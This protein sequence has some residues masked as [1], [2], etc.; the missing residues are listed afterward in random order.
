MDCVKIII[1]SLSIYYVRSGKAGCPSTCLTCWGNSDK[2]DSCD[3]NYF[4]VL[5][6]RTQTCDC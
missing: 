1:F 3:P 6:S 2:C 4:R 5:V